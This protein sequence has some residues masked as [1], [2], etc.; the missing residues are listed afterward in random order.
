MITIV[1]HSHIAIEVGSRRRSTLGFDKSNGE[2]I[3][4]IEL[5]LYLPL[6]TVYDTER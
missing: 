2:C 1:I 5:Y 6:V 4:G 3:L